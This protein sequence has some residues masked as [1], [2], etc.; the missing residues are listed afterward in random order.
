[1]EITKALITLIDVTSHS[2]SGIQR[3]FWYSHDDVSNNLKKLKEFLIIFFF[4][5]EVTLLTLLLM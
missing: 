1:M 3:N 2:I 4:P 5:A